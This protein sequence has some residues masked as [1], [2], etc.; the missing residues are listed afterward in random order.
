MKR[1]PG[2]NYKS[3]KRDAGGDSWTVWST[4]WW[5]GISRLMEKIN[6]KAWSCLAIVR[7]GITQGVGLRQPRPGMLL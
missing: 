4:R 1:S 6:I 3:H 2:N 7:S 5:R